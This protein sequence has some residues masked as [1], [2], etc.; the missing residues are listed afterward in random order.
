LQWSPPPPA[1][2]G[3]EARAYDVY[4][5]TTS[6]VDIGNPYNLIA[7]LRHGATQLFDTVAHPA[8]ARYYYA[9]AALDKGN[10]ESMPV[11]SSALLPEIVDVLSRIAPGFA[12]G[13]TYPEPVS[14]VLFI[15]YELPEQA[16]VSLTILDEHDRPVADLVR[17]S[18][19]AGRYI[20][21]GDLSKLKSG[22]YSLKL[23][24]GA[25]SASRSFR[26]QN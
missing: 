22:L 11:E 6:P 12:L 8:A 4:R 19:T 24:A 5:S 9:V 25:L 26:V 16:S 23:V 2:D 18:Q 3:D 13:R 1:S 17:G 21:S 14:S 20:A 10:N 7:I 15:P